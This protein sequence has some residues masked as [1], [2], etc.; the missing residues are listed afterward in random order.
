MLKPITFKNGLTVLRIPRSSAQTVVIGF[1]IPTGTSIE[2]SFE[3]G[4]AYLV[5]RLFW[6]GTDKHSSHKHL[7]L[8]LE[9]IGGSI[10]FELGEEYSGI[11]LTVPTQHQFKAMSLLAEVIQHSYFD[12]K[13]VELEKQRMIFQIQ[14]NEDNPLNDIQSLSQTHMYAGK[15]LGIK[16]I[17]TVES[18]LSINQKRIFEFVCSQYQPS[19][20]Y[21]VLSGNIETKKLLEL[22]EQ[23]WSMWNPKGGTLLSNPHESID[24]DVE[25]PITQY[26]QRG[27]GQTGMSIAFLLEGGMQPV[28]DDVSLD[29]SPDPDILVQ[30]LL[31]D[32]SKLIVLHS[33]IGGGFSSRLWTKC[34]E[35]EILF[36]SIHAQL[37]LFQYNSFFDIY[38]I[39][40]NSQFTFALESIFSVLESI[41]K[42][43]VSINELSKAKEF[44][45]GAF[46]REH[47]D[48]LVATLWQVKYMLA[49]GLTFEAEDL[50]KYVDA[51]DAPAI[52]SL[53]IDLFVPDRLVL[54]TV[55]PAKE[56]KLVNKLIK[57]YIG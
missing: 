20:G 53:A 50:M 48:L 57:K 14:Y 10:D 42:T 56:T 54:T 40:D 44:I 41:K 6:A 8:A 19:N 45:R 4:I 52:R 22:A 12:P 7:S 2:Y 31:S 55:G 47:E 32:W 29:Y 11:F 9:N 16:G 1:V 25:F 34:V 46:I 35:D 24:D 37:Q 39:S 21:L 28:L 51:V 15:A 38:G 13:D 33:I 5:Q 17:G 36:Q 30:N 18:M 26:K 43:T 23:E 49:S 3:R 27:V